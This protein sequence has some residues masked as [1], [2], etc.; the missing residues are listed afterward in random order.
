MTLE[1]SSILIV[2][3]VSSVRY[4]LNQNLRIM[5]AEKVAEAST[6]QQALSAIST[7][8]PDVVF[9]DIELPDSNGHELLSRIKALDP[10]CH[11]VIMSA[12]STVENVKRSVE[13]GA[14][15]FMAK[16]FTPQK[17]QATMNRICNL[18]QVKSA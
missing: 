5:G 17:I 16:P 15:G 1:Q 9:L 3:D 2:D 8:H 7:E 12:H 10:K 11:V 13:G 18:R 4:F 6:G 14:S